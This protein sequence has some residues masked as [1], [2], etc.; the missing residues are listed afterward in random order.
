M[1]EK[2]KEKMGKKEFGF[3]IDLLQYKSTTTAR[4]R[5][6]ETKITWTV[7]VVLKYERKIKFKLILRKILIQIQ[8]HFDD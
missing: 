7:I 6:I 8:T 4:Q 2:G 1:E 5:T 3:N